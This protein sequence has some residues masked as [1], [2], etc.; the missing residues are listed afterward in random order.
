[1]P[2]CEIVKSMKTPTAYSGMRAWVLPLAA[3]TSDAATSPSATMPIE[4]A[5]RSP[6]KLNWRGKK[7]SM[8][9]TAARRGKAAKDVFA[10]RNSRSAVNAWKR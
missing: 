3:T 1:M 10:A 5:S 8:A 6:R 4:N 7:P 2:A 9:S